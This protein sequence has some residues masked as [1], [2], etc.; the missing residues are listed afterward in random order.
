[1]RSDKEL[2][3]KYKDIEKAWNELKDQ[4]VIF[5]IRKCK[6]IIEDF[7]IPTRKKMK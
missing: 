4:D 1:M 5:F 6:E 3:D 2:A 7:E